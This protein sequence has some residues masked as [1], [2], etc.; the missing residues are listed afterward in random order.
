MKIPTHEVCTYLPLKNLIV[1]CFGTF[2][3]KEEAARA[4][5]L[6]SIHIFGE[7]AVLNFPIF[8]YW[9]FETKALKQNLPWSVP[10][11]ARNACSVPLKK[12]KRT[13]KGDHRGKQ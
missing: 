6:G 2:S 7:E 4:Y 13:T 8:D 12:R 10:Q 1:Q 3:N 9:D 5:D 11:S